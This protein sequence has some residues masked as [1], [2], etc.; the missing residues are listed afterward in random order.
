MSEVKEKGKIIIKLVDIE[1]YVCR[2]CYHY[3]RM[4]ESDIGIIGDEV[5]YDIC[6]ECK[7]DNIVL[8]KFALRVTKLEK[9][10]V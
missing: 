9:E 7:N 2:E 10:G 6:P 8:H 4:G 3:F 5:S 1:L